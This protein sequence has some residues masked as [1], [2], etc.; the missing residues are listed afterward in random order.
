MERTWERRV[1]L[2]MDTKSTKDANG[3]VNKTVAVASLDG[4]K[5]EDVHADK[6]NDSDSNSLLNLF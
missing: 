5:V 2:L 1:L 6:D 3:C 4:R